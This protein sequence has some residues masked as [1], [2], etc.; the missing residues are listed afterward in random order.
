[1]NALDYTAAIPIAGRSSSPTFERHGE[2][3]HQGRRRGR[4]RF[5]IHAPLLDDDQGR[6]RARG[7]AA[8]PRPG[9]SAGSCYDPLPDGTHCGLLRLP[10]GCARRGFVGSRR[11]DRMRDGR[12]HDLRGQGDASSPSR[13][14]ACSP[15]AARSSC[16]LPAAICGAGARRTGPARYVASA[17]PTSSGLTARAEASSPAPRRSRRGSSRYGARGPSALVVITG[18]EPMLQLDRDAGR[19]HRRSPRRSR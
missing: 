7:G 1:M 11:S 16:A 2:P 4:A 19:G 6:H 13:A 9:A 18:G 5:T 15:A 10:A 3:R 14:R 17:T 12:T 8:R